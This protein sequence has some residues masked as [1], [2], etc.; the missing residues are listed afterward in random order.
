MSAVPPNSPTELAGVAAEIWAQLE[1]GVAS[2]ASP[3]HTA[4]F[5]TVRRGAPRLRSVIVRKIDRGRGEIV[6]H[7]DFRSEKVGDLAAEPRVV[8]HFYSAPDKV[9][10][11]LTG[12]A[13][14]HRQ[15]TLAEATWAALSLSSRR[16]YCTRLAPGT[17]VPHADSGLSEALRERSPSAEESESGWPHFALIV[18]RIE[19]IEWL[20]LAAGNNHR[21]C[22]TRAGAT[23]DFAGQWLIP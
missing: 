5:G 22:F 11:Q 9:Q 14:L 2:A 23:D 13:R 10:I 6:C 17:P 8:F 1:Q 15:D 21:A 20:H 4:T 19:R 7:T 12:G 3:F 16:N 18:T